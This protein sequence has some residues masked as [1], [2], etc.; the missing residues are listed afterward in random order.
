MVKK[1]R[2]SFLIAHK[3]IYRPPIYCDS[4]FNMHKI[5]AEESSCSETDLI[6]FLFYSVWKVT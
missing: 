1:V 4:P 6:F 2:I 3:N 5:E